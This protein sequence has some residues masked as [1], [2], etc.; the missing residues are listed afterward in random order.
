MCFHC[1]HIFGV[2]LN[3]EIP[4]LES[5]SRILSKRLSTISITDDG[6]P[7]EPSPNP[8]RTVSP[9][10]NH[11]DGNSNPAGSYSQR[12]SAIPRPSYVRNGERT[13]AAMFPLPT[14]Q[15]RK[16]SAKR[17]RTQSTPFPFDATPSS[18]AVPNGKTANGVPSPLTSGSTSP[19]VHSPSLGRTTPT[20]SRIPTVS[21]RI[22]SGSQS[23][24]YGSLNGGKGSLP[25]NHKMPP[26][27]ATSADS[28]S[29]LGTLRVKGSSS[30]LA[31]ER[32]ADERA[33]FAND[34]SP[35]VLERE[36][37][38]R[39][40]SDEE[41]PYQHWYRGDVSRNGGVGEYRVGKR[42]EMLD[43][44]NYGHALRGSAGR[45]RPY[46]EPPPHSEKITVVPRKRAESVSS[47]ERASIYIDPQDETV[48]GRVLDEM[49]LTDIE[50]DET[51]Y[52]RDQY[53]RPHDSPTEFGVYPDHTQIPKPDNRPRTT[54]S[55]TPPSRLPSL[56][57]QTRIPQAQPR[58]NTQ[59][60]STVVPTAV[61]S[62]PSTPA[63]AHPERGRALANPQS[64][65]P[66][67]KTGQKRSKSAADALRAT[68]SANESSEYAG[69]A[70]AIPDTRSPLPRNG[71]WDEV[72]DVF[73]TME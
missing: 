73:I 63:K 15:P 18:S 72:C 68:P 8:S 12:P 71:N 40:S 27:A 66:T 6:P 26:L 55:S 30:S 29:Q 4:G 51:E 59:N 14:E 50:A 19:R 43:I 42:M 69:L 9:S 17:Q 1:V 33:P 35:T 24:H 22:R 2:V 45:S 10:Q 5:E 48:T 3:I 62:E 21:S 34:P 53:H 39:P 60:Q 64:K 67:K 57:S 41:R 61:T 44:A 11:V 70:D 31:R 65:P 52:E 46:E 47:R 58:V 7:S 20:P 32:I 37:T 36:F 28:G 56:K 23:S 16:A 38:G 54:S 13:A 49:P 25:P